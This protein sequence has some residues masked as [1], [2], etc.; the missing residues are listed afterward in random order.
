[1]S[2]LALHLLGS[3]RIEFD[4]RPIQVTT[5]KA[6]ALAAYL[7]II[8]QAHT[9]ETLTALLWPELDRQRSRAVLRSTLSALKRSCMATG[10]W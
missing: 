4:G 6:I 10:Y 9:R 2:H 8:T 3:P 1:M 7:A 5:R